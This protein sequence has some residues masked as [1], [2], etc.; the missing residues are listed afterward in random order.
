M[1]KYTATNATSGQDHLF[2]VILVIRTTNNIRA[3]CY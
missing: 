1:L 2:V 3:I